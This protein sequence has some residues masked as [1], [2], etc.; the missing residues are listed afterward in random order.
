MPNLCCWTGGG[1]YVNVRQLIGGFD[2]VATKCC[3]HVGN[4]DGSW[5]DCNASMRHPDAKAKVIH[6]FSLKSS[7]D[8]YKQRYGYHNDAYLTFQSTIQALHTRHLLQHF[9]ALY[10]VLQKFSTVLSLYCNSKLWSVYR[11]YRPLVSCQICCSAAPSVLLST[12][13]CI[14][15]LSYRRNSTVITI[16]Y[17]GKS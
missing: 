6:G 3:C 1:A 2:Q 10:A 17:L 8:Y 13:P 14:R 7:D 12:M 16:L 15:T 5:P 9:S 11:S 4:N